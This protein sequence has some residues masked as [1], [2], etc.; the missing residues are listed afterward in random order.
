MKHH[1][2]YA[3]SKPDAPAIILAG[4]GK[5]ITWQ[6]HDRKVNQIAQYYRD[7]GLKEKD[8]IAVLLENCEAYIQIIDAA[9]DAGLLLTTISTHLK[10]DETEYVINNSES[11]LLI[12][13]GAFSELA[14][15][16]IAST[17]NVT[18]RL[19]LN[20][21]IDGYDSFEETIARY[22]ETPIE[23]G[24][25]GSFMLYSSGT[26]GRPKGIHWD[27][28]DL[29][30][31]T[32]DPNLEMG[33]VRSQSIFQ[34]SHFTI[35]HLPPLQSPASRLDAR[36]CSWKRLMPRT[37]WPVFK[38]IRP[39]TPSGCLPCLSEFSSCLTRSA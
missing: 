33:A 35:R 27:V 39:P 28:P 13:S 14:G 29:P 38:S 21:T 11:K 36:S 2:T 6:E 12:T 37:R 23:Y 25:G 31:G 5:I 15:E 8:H 4:S 16:L 34:H 19:M 26:T 9:I 22:D 18:N 32:M 30:V 10:R 1:S 20:T 17:P 24:I 3:A 7:I